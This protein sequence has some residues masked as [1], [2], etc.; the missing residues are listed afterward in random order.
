MGYLLRVLRTIG[1]LVLSGIC[2]TAAAAAPAFHL[3]DLGQGTPVDVNSSGTVIGMDTHCKG[4]MPWVQQNGTRSYLP[5]PPGTTCGVVRRISNSGLVV[6]RADLRPVLWK[7]GPAGYEAVLLPMPA[8]ATAGEPAAVNSTGAVLLNYGNPANYN[9]NLFFTGSHPFL[10][11]ESGGLVDLVA[12]HRLTQPLHGADMTESG[13]ILLGTGTILEP[14]GS[15][16]PA[17]AWHYTPGGYRWNGFGATRL[18]E[19]G[20]FVGVASLGASKGGFAV[21]SFAPRSGWRILYPWI[22]TTRWPTIANGIDERG[23]VEVFAFGHS[24]ATP[25]GESLALGD[26]VAARGYSLTGTWVAVADNGLMVLSARNPQGGY[27]AVLLTP[28]NGLPAP[29]L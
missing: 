10:Y 11:T 8:G 27:S 17:P 16:T 20:E 9:G 2:A 26:L 5:L 22:N 28:A 19:A 15:T 23:N 24:Y 4:A 6:G 1:C 12:K 21:A 29:G 7:P 25:G 18:N 14:D 3:R 13:R